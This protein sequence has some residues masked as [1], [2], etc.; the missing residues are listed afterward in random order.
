M[1]GMGL[2]VSVYVRYGSR[3]VVYCMLGMGLGRGC[4]MLGMG[5]GARVLVHRSTRLLGVP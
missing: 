1:L 2:A 3:W 5:L 4:A